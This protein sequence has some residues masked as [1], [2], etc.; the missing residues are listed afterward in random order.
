VKSTT[1]NGAKQRETTCGYANG[2]DGINTS[3]NT[4]ALFLLPTSRTIS[5][6]FYDHLALRAPLLD[7]GQR[8]QGR[9]EW[10]DPVYD[11]TNSTGVDERAERA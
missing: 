7:V 2:V 5:I 1:R 4:R 11:G 10:K 8:F 6:D 3:S 9:L